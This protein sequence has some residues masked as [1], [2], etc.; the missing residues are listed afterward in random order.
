MLFFLLHLTL[1]TFQRG[2]K[3]QPFF[4]GLKGSL[5]EDEIFIK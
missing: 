1:G 2:A 3:E 4:I 5:V